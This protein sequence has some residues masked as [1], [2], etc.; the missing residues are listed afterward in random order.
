MAEAKVIEVNSDS[1]DESAVE[2]AAELIRDGG[3]VAF[4]TETVYGI[5]VSYLNEKALKRLYEV[6]ERPDD[7]PFTLHISDTGMLKEMHCEV[8]ELASK[9]IEKFWPGPLT[10]ILKTGKDKLGF[11]MPDNAVAKLLIKK[12]GVPI[13]VPS[14]NISGEMPPTDVKGISDRIRRSVDLILDGGKTEFG[15][16]STIVDMTVLPYKIIRIGA[17]PESDIAKIYDTFDGNQ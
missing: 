11:R 13:A 8:T 7:K 16:E 14:A 10:L 15:K 12:S 4:P 5:G 2:F 6:K 3:L 9:L 1:P 17:I